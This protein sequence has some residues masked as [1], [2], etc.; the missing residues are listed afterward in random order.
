MG[1]RIA[2]KKFRVGLDM[3]QE[4]FAAGLGVSRFTYSLIEQGKKDGSLAFWLGF[5]KKYNL[6]P[7]EL[8]ELIKI[9][10]V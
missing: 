3:N 9:E 2:L 5:K 1:K 7:S 10:K 6:T 4:E 8:L